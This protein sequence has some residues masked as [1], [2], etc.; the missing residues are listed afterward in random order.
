MRRGPRRRQRSTRQ[1]QRRRRRRALTLRWRR[2]L[3][4]HLH[5]AQALKRRWWTLKLRRGRPRRRRPI[6]PLEGRKTR[7]RGRRTPG[8]KARAF[9][10][11]RK[12]PARMKREA[13][14]RAPRRDLSLPQARSAMPLGLRRALRPPGPLAMRGPWFLVAGARAQFAA[15]PPF[16]WRGR[17]LTGSRPSTSRRSLLWR[18][19]A[20][21]LCGLGPTFMRP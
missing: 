20:L 16:A 2:P 8:L 18:R 19:N 5:Q 7:P 3:R 13:L 10:A 9:R 14:T 17:R 6:L 15:M 1:R 11:P 21:T 4:R 12:P